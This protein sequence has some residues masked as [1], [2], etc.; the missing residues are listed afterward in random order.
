MEL[1][2]ITFAD[3]G[4]G[5]VSWNTTPITADPANAVAGT[6]YFANTTGGAF[7]VTLP[8]SPSAGDIV[9][10]KDYAATFVD[11]NLTVARNG[12]NIDGVAQDAILNENNLAVTFIYV[13]GTQGWK[14]INSDAGTYGPGYIVAE[15]GEVTICGDYKIHTFNGPGIFSVSSAGNPSGSTQV[16][17]MVIGGGA[18]GGGQSQSG[19]GGAGGFRESHSV[20]VSGCYTASPLATPTGITVSAQNYPIVIGAGGIGGNI[21]GG[22]YDG[23]PTTALGI[24][25]AGGGAGGGSGQSGRPGASGGG[26][27]E[28]GGGGSG[29]QPPVSPP[30]GNN[31]G[32]SGSPS[33]AG[34]GGAGGNGSPSGPQN[35]GNGGVGATTE[36]LGTSLS[37]AGGGGGGGYSPSGSGGTGTSG[38]GDGGDYNN[39][40]R[41][42]FAGKMNTGGGGGGNGWPVSNAA[43]FGGSG[44]VVIRYKYR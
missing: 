10:I 23:S 32:P 43:G 12:S 36:I 19:G 13:D 42:G 7:T 35:G 4:G 37:F 1:G 16:D 44:K 2:N 5:A 26:G 9:A 15:G 28:N 29:N 22:D 21:P 39:N 6:G 30:Q 11:N 14:A 33:G 20:P 24:T 40:S 17:Y 18:S 3:A 41:I 34:G 38:G 25:S 31:G 27:G 8:T